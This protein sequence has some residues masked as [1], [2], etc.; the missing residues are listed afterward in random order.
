[1]N[2]KERKKHVCV[3]V[4]NVC[5]HKCIY[6]CMYVCMYACMYV[7]V[8]VCV[9]VCMYTCM[10]GS[11]YYFRGHNYPVNIFW[12]ISVWYTHNDFLA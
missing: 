9:Y 8:Y 3:Y 10:P 12:C 11:H 5:M 7:C 1:M 2:T 4:C 6:V